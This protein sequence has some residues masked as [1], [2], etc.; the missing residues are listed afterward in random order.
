[1][2]ANGYAGACW[3][4]ALIETLPN[5]NEDSLT[6]QR[7]CED[8]TGNWTLM[9]Q[10]CVVQATVEVHDMRAERIP[11]DVTVGAFHKAFDPVSVDSWRDNNQLLK[12]APGYHETLELSECK[13]C[14]RICV[15]AD[16]YTHS[17]MGCSLTRCT[18]VCMVRDSIYDAVRPHRDTTPIYI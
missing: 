5:A 1:V 8:R 9:Q 11:L 18:H 2:H 14:S 17:R 3:Q 12:D 16:E 13:C 15:Y 10:C 4:G 7:R 6:R